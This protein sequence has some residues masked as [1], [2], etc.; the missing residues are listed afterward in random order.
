[1]GVE[2]LDLGGTTFYLVWPICLGAIEDLYRYIMSNLNLFSVT[3]QGTTHL[4]ETEHPNS[5]QKTVAGGPFWILHCVT[6]FLQCD[7]VCLDTFDLQL[8]V[9]VPRGHHRQAM[10]QGYEAKRLLRPTQFVMVSQPT[11]SGYP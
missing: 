6:H 9:V 7:A 2:T 5:G 10:S 4:I 11:G 3:A 1:M 8:I